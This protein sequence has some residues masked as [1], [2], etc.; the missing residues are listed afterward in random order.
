[1]LMHDREIGR[2]RSNSSWMGT[3]DGAPRQT[4]PVV[5]LQRRVASALRFTSP[6]VPAA[7]ATMPAS[8][9]ADFRGL[10]LV[11]SSTAKVGSMRRLG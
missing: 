5:L 7:V 9:D 3:Q 8:T 2:G 6:N 4:A 11:S 10:A 1:M